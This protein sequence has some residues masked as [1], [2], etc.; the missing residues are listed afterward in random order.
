[1]YF[2]NVGNVEL[3][4]FRNQKAHNFTISLTDLLTSDLFKVETIISNTLYRIYPLFYTGKIYSNNSSNRILENKCIICNKTNEETYFTFVSDETKDIVDYTNYADYY[5][6]GDSLTANEFN[7]IINLFRKNTIHQDSFKLK[8]GKITGEYGEY[9]FNID[10]TTIVD[11]GILITD[12][13]LTNLG[14]VKLQNPSFENSTYTLK[15]KISHMTDINVC[16]VNTSNIIVEELTIELKAGEN[17]TIP[18]N[19][20]DYN[21]VV[22]FDAVVEIKHD[23]PIIER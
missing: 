4:K 20:L 8:Q 15:L 21:Y 22:G 2:S 12:E 1:M 10:S 16:E 14:T 7:T 19:T 6:V 23:K 18:F 11:T 13:T 9:V 5:D 3:Q 17:V